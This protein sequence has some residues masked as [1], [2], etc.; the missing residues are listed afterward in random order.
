M[1][2]GVF[3]HG[4]GCNAGQLQSLVQRKDVGAL[5]FAMALRK[6]CHVFEKIMRVRWV[7]GVSLAIMG[8]HA[9]PAFQ[10]LI[11]PVKSIFVRKF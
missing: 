2:G 5:S 9:N 4:N 7:N 3:Q 6:R 8:T 11:F 1:Y 10:K